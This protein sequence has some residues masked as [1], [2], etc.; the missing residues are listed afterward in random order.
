MS[1]RKPNPVS[2]DDFRTELSKTLT[3]LNLIQQSINSVATVLNS[4]AK[5]DSDINFVSI[6]T[7]ESCINNLVAE[8]P[9]RI[10]KNLSKVMK[11]R[12]IT[13]AKEI[14]AVR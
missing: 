9:A 5:N 2:K 12:L 10:L 4:T 1:R 3:K 8:D 11:R 14:V 7:L 6:E 13:K